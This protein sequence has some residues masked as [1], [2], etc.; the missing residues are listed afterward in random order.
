M[1]L[2]LSW[3]LAIFLSFPAG[4]AAQAQNLY[5]ILQEIEK[6]GRPNPKA[7][8]TLP[9]EE[10]LENPFE[11]P[12]PLESPVPNFEQAPVEPAE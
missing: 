9:T 2:I 4:L 5:F 10:K 11:T 7:P 12:Q 6:A 3:I 8:E 1:R